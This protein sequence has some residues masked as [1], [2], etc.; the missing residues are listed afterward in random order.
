[1]AIG[2]YTPVKHPSLLCASFFART[3]HPPTSTSHPTQPGDDRDLHD[4]NAADT[5]TSPTLWSLYAVVQLMAPNIS[6]SI[7]SCEEITSP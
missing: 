7:S 2:A 4:E 5:S 6:S 3:D 1:M